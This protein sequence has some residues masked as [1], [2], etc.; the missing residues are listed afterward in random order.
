V[1]DFSRKETRPCCLSGSAYP[2]SAPE[3]E[4]RLDDI[5]LSQPAPPEPEGRIQAL[6]APHIDFSAGYKIYAK[7]YQMVNY[8][9]PSRVFVLGVGHKMMDQLYCLTEKDFETPLGIVKNETP[10]VKALQEAGR[11]V[12]CEDDFAHRAEHSIEFQAVFLRH[13]LSMDFSLIPILCGAFQTNLREYS[14]DAFLEKAGP[15]LAKLRDIVAE[16]EHETLV[17]SG[18]DFSHIGPKFGHTDPADFLASR[19]QDHDRRLLEHLCHLDADG[20]WE[21]S[22]R[23][24][25]RFNVC[26]FSAMASLLEVIPPCEGRVLDYD[27]WHE[28]STRSAVSFA[29]V[30]FA[31]AGHEQP[32]A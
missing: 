7:A 4:K 25:D 9:K 1:D 11:D 23:V 18:V 30:V 28:Q 2:K 16:R 31:H 24:Q 5:L 29:A 13:L 17:L 20:F 21:E 26:G 14:R 19:A 15:L 10:V 27:M 8:I 32:L 3:L 22:R 12:V 6:V